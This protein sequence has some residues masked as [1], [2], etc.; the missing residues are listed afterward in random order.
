M[1]G[2]VPEDDAGGV[3]TVA[4][5]VVSVGHT[6]DA[7]AEPKATLMTPSATEEPRARE[8]H[9]LTRGTPE[10][11]EMVAKTGAPPGGGRGREDDA[12]TVEDVTLCVVPFRY[13]EGSD[14]G[15]VVL[16]GCASD[17]GWF[18]FAGLANE[19]ARTAPA[20]MLR[21]IRTPTAPARPACRRRDR[22]RVDVRR[23][24][25]RGGLEGTAPGG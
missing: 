24:A 25:A 11:G 12:G 16:G 19:S 10:A 4:R 6:T 8:G 3:G 20:A 2:T 1:T 21:A 22:R 9:D 7:G 23:G 15:D 14:V 18:F 13:D 17:P 5:H